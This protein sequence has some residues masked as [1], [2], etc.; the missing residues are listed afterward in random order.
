MVDVNNPPQNRNRLWK[1]QPV[2]DA[3][4]GGCNK[5]LRQPG[6]YSIDEQMVP[7]VGKTTLKQ[8]VPNKPRPV[9]LKNFVITTSDGIMIDF[10]MYQGKD[11][12]LPMAKEMGLGP[13]VVLR[14]KESV[15]PLSVLYFDRYF[16]TISLMEKLTAEQFYATGTMMTNRLSE[17]TFKPEHLKRGQF[18]ERV[19]PDGKLVALKWMD[20]QSVV[21]LSSV[22]GS[23]PI[24]FVK[25]WSK[26]DSVYVDVECP[27][28][29]VT[30]NKNMG[31][32][33]LLNQL[34]EVYRTWFKT[35]KWT[36]KVIIHFLDLAVVNAW[37]QYRKDCRD[38]KRP[39]K[40][41]MDLLQFR[42]TLAETLMSRPPDERQL[43]HAEESDEEEGAKPSN[44]RAPMPAVDKRYDGF[45]HWPIAEGG[46]PPRTCRMETCSSRSRIKCEKCQVYLCLNKDKDCFKQFHKRN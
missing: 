36:L 34:V 37:L 44:W 4:K 35:K 28:A 39:K 26:K 16:T 12:N 14:L 40:N 29:I 30:Y 38:C 24:T 41:I 2:L 46:I 19:S 23:Q 22:C 11:T 32:V 25:R 18:E 31:G 5:I 17:I 42:M 20:N 1:V 15:P 21:V 27:A 7:F 33:D 9:G 8:Y 43:Y 45:E 3:V 6:N 13:A 10:E